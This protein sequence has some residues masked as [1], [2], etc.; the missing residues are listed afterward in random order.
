ME[1]RS[2][3]D[4][5]YISLKKK[6]VSRAKPLNTYLSP[7]TS[8]PAFHRSRSHLIYLYPVLTGE[9]G[10]MQ[11]HAKVTSCKPFL[12]MDLTLY[13]FNVVKRIH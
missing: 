6:A 11:I 1:L 7:S 10:W 5:I 8:L 2:A 13:K 3:I 12:K 4:I 9:V